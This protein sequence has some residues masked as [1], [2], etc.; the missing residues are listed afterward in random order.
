[1]GVPR[2]VTRLHVIGTVAD[3]QKSLVPS[4][5]I[6]IKNVDTGFTRAA[7]T[8][9]QGRYRL[10]AILPSNYSQVGCQRELAANVG[11]DAGFIYDR[12]CD[13]VGIMPLQP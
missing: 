10:A 1:L 3:D 6:A 2:R 4:A 13:A 9:T 11:L 8:D 5:T 12:G 7:A